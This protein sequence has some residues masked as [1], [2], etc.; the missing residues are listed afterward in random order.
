MFQVASPNTPPGKTE[1]EV[2]VQFNREFVDAGSPNSRPE[3]LSSASSFQSIASTLST[4]SG[5]QSLPITPQG[6]AADTSYVNTDIPG[7]E[8]LI[9]A[10]GNIQLTDQLDSVVEEGSNYQSIADS[11]LT[12]TANDNSLKEQE[13]NP[14]NLSQEEDFAS[15]NNSYQLNGTHDL[16]SEYKEALE[17][18]FN[19]NDT[20]ETVKDKSITNHI[21]HQPN[22]NFLLNQT[23]DLSIQSNN[24]L[25]KTTELA[26]P[27]EEVENKLPEV[28]VSNSADNPPALI[29]SS[30]PVADCNST[31]EHLDTNKSDV[32]NLT[33]DIVDDKKDSSIDCHS[34][35]AATAVIQSSNESL[36]N[37]EADRSVSSL[38]DPLNLPPESNVR[39]EDHNV[40]TSNAEAFQTAV[41]FTTVVESA[42]KESESIIQTAVKEEISSEQCAP[43]SSTDHSTQITP[44][45]T[46]QPSSS[47]VPEVYVTVNEELLEETKAIEETHQ[48]SDIHNVSTTATIPEEKV[49]EIKE[50][51]LEE[52][53]PTLSQDITEAAAEAVE[54]EVSNS[55]EPDFQNP[56]VQAETIVPSFP[57][58]NNLQEFGES[59]SDYVPNVV[60][61]V[62]PFPGENSTLNPESVVS[63]GSV[64]FEG[65]SNQT[66]TVKE[67]SFHSIGSEGVTENYN[68]FQPEKQSTSLNLDS[69]FL[70]L[71][72]AAQG[73]AEEIRNKSLEFTED[74]DQFFNADSDREFPS[75]S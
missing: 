64:T 17:S 75:A 44:G 67:E 2:K 37:S 8:D 49:N 74:S 32:L 21:P 12:V 57:P 61:N 35:S 39:E 11:T 72:L 10:C 28:Q 29:E 58:L 9:A 15:V 14:Q 70:K 7:L 65:E 31:F 41:N 47:L 46:D 26:Y 68:A 23:R 66:I 19:L 54:P 16:T 30:E 38:N 56:I 59:K 73:I 53:E 6:I 13:N 63:N 33:H 18:S 50:E 71:E 27:S 34:Q 48:V 62:T 4:T 25:N 51:K 69:N 43:D 45:S 3:S 60:I 52:I 5:N 20:R 42:S 24:S 1:H 36:L 40:S 55:T 22:D